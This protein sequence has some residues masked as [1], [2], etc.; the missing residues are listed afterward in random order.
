MQPFEYLSR[1]FSFFVF[2][3]TLLFLFLFL[4]FISL[5]P[6]QPYY[7]LSSSP[8]YALYRLISYFIDNFFFL[9]FLALVDLPF[10]IFASCTYSIR[11]PFK[12]F[13][14]RFRRHFVSNIS[15]LDICV[16]QFI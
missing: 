5:A 13:A 8:C 12:P 16:R 2:G 9:L 6:L 15:L 11:V 4:R 7:V 10:A 1:T 14:G 3:G